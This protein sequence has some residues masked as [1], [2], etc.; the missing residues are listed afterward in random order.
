MTPHAPI[1][2]DFATVA[3]RLERGETCVIQ[4]R[5][6]DDLLTPVAAYLRLA[7]DQANSFLLESVE[8]GAWRGRYSAIGLDPDLMWQCRDGVASEARGMD[9]AARR[10]TPIDAEP[11]T[12]L[13]DVI[14]AAHC[15]LPDDAPPLASGLFGYVGYD[16]V[17]Y[18]ERL[19]T[20]AAPDPLGLPE[21]ILLRPQTMVVFDALKQ[22]I[23]VYCPVRPGEFSA[24]EAYDAAVERLQT[25]LQKLAGGTPEPA[26]PAGQLGARQSNQSEDSYRQAVD[27]ARAYIRAGDAF[28]VVPSQRF[29]ADYPADPFWLYR[30]LR[31]LNPSPFLFFFR[32]DGFEVVG[33]SPEILVRLRDDVVTIRPIAGTRPRGRT[34][35]EDDA[36]EADL[37]ADPKER[38]EHLMLLDLGRND[39]GRI[40]KPGS[41][42]ITAREIV[43]RYSHVMH[44]VSNV[45][46]D[47]AAGEDVVS[48][49]FAGFP[50]GTVSGA[51]KVRAMEI[52]DEL[53]PHRRGV[54]AGAVGYFSADGGMDT[55][56][57]LRTA[58]FK[59]GRMYVQAGAG[60]VL[61]SDPESERVETVNKAEALFRAAID[62]LD[63]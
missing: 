54:Y 55:A 48:A 35:A 28:Q 26:R 58:V 63:N 18:L 1:T 44:I 31:R 53:E 45:E 3:E 25:T 13:R 34:P 50:A 27:A 61:D 33:S 6:V 32:F 40:A 10:F 42:R 30:S 21:S 9:V 15:P 4:A 16:M 60:V 24:R 43:E 38:S 39:V 7:A 29:S 59:D 5:R 46:G 49:L 19:P 52:I 17:R 12:A 14:E 57:A 8:G 47:L 36:H 23:Q 37:L 56:I 51:P 22:E 2:P 62:S 11:M 20:G 41:V